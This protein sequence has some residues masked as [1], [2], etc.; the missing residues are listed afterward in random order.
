MSMPLVAPANVRLWKSLRSISGARAQ[1]PN[2]PRPQQ[3]RGGDEEADDGSGCPAPIV[4]LDESQSEN[5]EPCSR[6]ADADRVETAA[7]G[8][9]MFGHEGQ[10][11]KDRGKADGDI[12][13]EDPVP[14]CILCE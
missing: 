3:H 5:E 7:G 8:A 6:D 2:H 13:E 4:T 14:V 9:A 1:L 11:E 10:H 12:D